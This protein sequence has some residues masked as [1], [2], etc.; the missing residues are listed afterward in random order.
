MLSVLLFHTVTEPRDQQQTLVHRSK[1]S[2]KSKKK[3]CYLARVA[4]VEFFKPLCDLVE[5]RLQVELGQLQVSSCA[6]VLSLAEICVRKIRSESVGMQ[7]LYLQIKAI[8]T[9]IDFYAI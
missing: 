9:I 6:E 7:I 5:D 4:K 3:A 8:L 2:K 1:K